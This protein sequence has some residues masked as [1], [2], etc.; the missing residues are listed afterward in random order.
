MDLRLA[1]RRGYALLPVRGLGGVR[2]D[3]DVL[4][5][6]PAIRPGERSPLVLSLTR[7]GAACYKCPESLRVRGSAPK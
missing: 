1:V 5:Y 7:H 6:D 2:V 4:R 3:G